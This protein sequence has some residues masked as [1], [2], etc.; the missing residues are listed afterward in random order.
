MKKGI[1]I[2]IFLLIVLFEN[3]CSSSNSDNLED[4]FIGST[5]TRE[6][7]VDTEY[8]S[9]QDDGTFSYYCSCGNPVDD[10]DLCSS[11]Q[12]DENNKIIR[13]ICE[14]GCEKIEVIHHDS[15]NLVLKF[16]D[17]IRKFKKAQ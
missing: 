12:Y 2:I 10:S 14:Y 6:I 17:E 3:A 13:F 5:W 9:F 4:S 8:L 11:Y 1:A 16:K 7:E 15:H